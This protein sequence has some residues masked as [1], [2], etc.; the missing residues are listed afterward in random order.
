MRNFTVL[1]V[2][3][4]L[5]PIAYAVSVVDDRQISIE[6]KRAPMRIVTLLPSLAESV[7]ALNACERL[8]GTDNFADWP[9]QVKALPKLGGLYDASVEAIVRLK[10]DLVLAGKS[11]RI[12]SR[13][14]SLGIQVIALEPKNLSDVKR[15]LHVIAQ[16]LHL[17]QPDEQAKA[18]WSSAMQS[19]ELAAKSLP[20]DV[21]GNTIYFETSTGGYAAGES[22]FMGGVIS[23]LGLRNI[24]DKS[25]GAFPQVNPE[26]VV[27]AN[28]HWIVL[29]EPLAQSLSQRPGWRDMAAVKSN[30]LCKLTMAQGNVLVR[31]GPRIGEAAQVLVNCFNRSAAP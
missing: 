15:S 26:F 14:E 3:S 8:V 20:S 23:K 6:I 16:A 28:P 27:R 12:T 11:T 1:F 2:L 5:W 19:L 13:L 31:P 9:A 21:L 17:P 30:R 25:M 10:P 29:A 7:C 22:S 18:V 4:L 24:I